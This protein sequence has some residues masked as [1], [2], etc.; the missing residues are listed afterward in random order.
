MVESLELRRMLSVTPIVDTAPEDFANFGHSVAVNPTG[1][2][3]LV[4]SPQHSSSTAFSVGEVTLV[5]LA[6]KQPIRTIDAPSQNASGQFGT[7]VAWVGD[8]AVITAPGINAV[9]VY[10]DVLNATTAAPAT[11]SYP[12][13]PAT[14]IGANGYGGSLAIFGDD[15]LI[16][17]GISAGG[18][19]LR[20]NVDGSFVQQ[21]APTSGY[22]RFGTA[23][24]SQAGNVYIS[25]R[26][27]SEI[28]G[29]VLE[30]HADTGTLGRTIVEPNGKSTTT[31][32]TPFGT[33]LAVAGDDLLVGVYNNDGGAVYQIDLPTYPLV[34]DSV[35]APAYSLDLAS[36]ILG[37]SIAVNGGQVALGSFNGIG[38]SVYIY[39]VADQSLVTTVGPEDRTGSEIF[40]NVMAA[41]PN[42]QFLIADAAHDY[43]GMLFDSG[44]VYV[45]TPDITTPPNGAPVATLSGSHA[46]AVR[47][48]TV[49][50]TG[51]FTDA[52]ATD[53]HTV[54]WDFGD[55]NII[56][57]HPTTDAGALNV[58]HAFTATGVYTVTMTISDGTDSDTEAFIVTVTATSL[59]GDVFYIGGGDG[60]DSVAIKKNDLG[61]SNITVNGEIITYTG[62]R[63]VIY[64]GG[65]ADTITVSPAANVAIEAHGGAGNDSVAGGSGHDIIVG[66]ADNDVLYGGAGRD[67]LIGG[68]GA[69][70]VYGEVAD[71]ILI[72]PL[73]IH[74]NDPAAL[75]AIMGIWTGTADFA[76]RVT[77]LKD[78]LLTPGEEVPNLSD[79]FADTL[80][81]KNGDDWFVYDASEDLATDIKS[82]ESVAALYFVPTT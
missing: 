82:D 47:N 74:D 46:A 13:G 62:A 15:L 79:T 78:G 31:P 10:S 59:Q 4:A 70:G 36:G 45:Y 7:R 16:G 14:L 50:F 28:E 33:S 12:A 49:T 73:T 71:D 19:V 77:T 3:A 75:N 40:G 76:T 61:G 51:S 48:Q 27:S 63:V 26:D 81:G 6:T 24:A 57:A 2:L 37:G 22:T 18:E 67:L 66:G 9:Y 11:L 42:G 20:V 34:G 64:G 39:N 80:T 32:N 25:A 72:A 5:D 68:N 54:S 41:M 29:A 17:N 56:A 52:D 38:G 55:G 21:Y 44:A 30:F 35:S 69:D 65:G 1:T 23:I 60:N 53:T 43:Q 58:S 8:S